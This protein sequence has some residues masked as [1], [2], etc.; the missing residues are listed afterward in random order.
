MFNVLSFLDGAVELYQRFK[1]NKPFFAGKLGNAELMCLYNYLYA[2][3]TNQMPI[4]WSPIVEKEIYI[5]AGV[6]PQTEDARIYFCRSIENAIKN[7]DVI[8]PWNS[9]LGDF[10]K[11]FIRTNNENCIMIDLCS[12]EP[13]YSGIPWTW[14]LKDKNV[15]VISPFINSI[16][17]QFARKDKIWSNNLLPGFN[18][19]P[20]YHPTSKAISNQTQNPY[21]TWKDMVTDLQDKI[22]NINFDVAL[23][24]TG[25][26][27]LP[28]CSH[29]KTLGK[30]AIHLGGPLQI[31]FGIKG[32]RWDSNRTMQ[33]FYNEYWIRPSAEETPEKNSNVE[34]GCYW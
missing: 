16:V 1:D 4:N 26:S 20:L 27:S 17:K 25:A 10:E 29:I 6:F 19:I 24:G 9:G 14:H 30:Q 18:L 15:L 13:Y 22:A 31:L 8:S 33:A 7:I 3:H 2:A 34:G 11:K 5:N 21:D 23:V 12:L 28:L 32:K